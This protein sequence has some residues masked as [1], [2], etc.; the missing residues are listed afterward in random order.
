[1]PLL[2]EQKNQLLEYKFQ[3]KIKHLKYLIQH[4]DET[5]VLIQL[6]YQDYH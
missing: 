5:N 4:F 2:K 3:E 6:F 1:M